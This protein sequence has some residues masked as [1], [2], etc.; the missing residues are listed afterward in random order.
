MKTLIAL[1]VACMAV[2]LWVGL[3]QADDAGAGAGADAP[4]EITEEAFMK[5]ICGASYGVEVYSTYIK[6][7]KANPTGVVDLSL[8][9]DLGQGLQNAKAELAT[10]LGGYKKYYKKPFP[11]WRKVPFCVKMVSDSEKLNS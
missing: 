4:H 9:Y 6:Q 11:G 5:G 1:W 10:Y 7:E 3:A 2:V 8:L